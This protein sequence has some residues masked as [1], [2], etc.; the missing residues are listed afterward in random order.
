MDITKI[1]SDLEL[2]PDA[3]FEL[4][5]TFLEEKAQL[6][7]MQDLTKHLLAKWKGLE[8]GP[9]TEKERLA[10]ARTE[11]LT[12]LDGILEQAK[13]TAGKAAEFHREERRF[14]ALRS[15]NKNV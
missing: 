4:E 6:E 9:N 11:Y 8:S 10:L 3:I 2:L 7:Y 12:H 5:K 13:L 1:R 14:E 15:L